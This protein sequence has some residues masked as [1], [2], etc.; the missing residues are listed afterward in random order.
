[1][2][3]RK[4][5]L[6]TPSAFLIVALLILLILN[7]FAPSLEKQS[8]GIVLVECRSFYS[9]HTDNGDTLFL[10]PTVGG[11]A[12]ETIALRPEEIA[13]STYSSGVA[14]SKNGYVV[15]SD[16]IAARENGDAIRKNPHAVLEKVDRQLDTTFCNIKRQLEELKYYANTHSPVDDGYQSVMEFRQNAQNTLK[17]IEALQTKLKRMLK[18]KNLNAI[19]NYW[20]RIR[21]NR[22]ADSTKI[23]SSSATA[24]CVA[25]QDSSLILL[26]IKGGTPLPE[27]YRFKTFLWS[28]DHWPLFWKSRYLLAFQHYVLPPEKRSAIL[29]DV[30][31]IQE[32]DYPHFTLAEGGAIV[33]KTGQLTGIM[34]HRGIVTASQI[35]K[36]L[37]SVRHSGSTSV[38]SQQSLPT[39]TANSASSSKTR[40]NNLT[41]TSTQVVKT[42]IPARNFVKKRKAGNL[43]HK[44]PECKGYEGR[45]IGNKRSG[46]GKQAYDNGSTYTG[47]WIDNKRS[48][49][50]VLVDSNGIHYEGVWQSDT[51]VTGSVSDRYGYYYGEFDKRLQ[52]NGYGRLR[53]PSGCYYEGDWKEGKREGFGFSIEPQ[54]IVRCGIW[55]QDKFRGEQMVYTQRRVYG[56]DISRYQH[57]V[58]RKRYAIHWNK[59]RITGIG[60]LKNRRIHGKIDYPIS[61]VY[62]KASEGI[63]IR[64]RYYASDAQAAR[65]RG[66]AVGAYHFF[67]TKP[68][69]AQ[70]L[71]FLKTAK[72]RKGD[73][74][75]VLDMEL[76]DRQIEKMGGNNVLFRNIIQWC[77]VVEKHCGVAPILYLSQRFVNK[78]LPYIPHNKKRRYKVWIARYGEYKPYVHLLYWQ[79]SPYGSVNGIHGYVDINVFN[80]THELFNEMVRE[81]CVP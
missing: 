50:G 3:H 54:K 55:H 15:T 58:G 16:G 38:S 2:Y 46:Q 74:P 66:I 65:R 31:D 44:A 41:Y 10:K 67:T 61:F 52:R 29:P 1:M 9:I 19:P 70:A 57:E 49:Y 64:N 42:K 27:T 69:K 36:L 12:L 35:N 81:D 53:M 78:Y 80:G 28:P 39:E 32:K 68:G 40:K 51:L 79:L 23:I 63:S 77:D 48:G 72:P 6:I 47:E 25:R 45:T 24:E 18:Q 62:I 14:I 21:H 13:D 34:T 11:Y 71:Y 22:I 73:L 4:K 20:F 76:S 60:S 26:Q 43:Y 17:K 33:T 5:K 56:I 8:E 59:L 75:P 7:P 30:I 37:K